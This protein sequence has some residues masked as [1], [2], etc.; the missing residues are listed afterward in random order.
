MNCVFV[1]RAARGLALAALTALIVMGGAGLS[2]AASS[3]GPTVDL[4]SAARLAPDGRTVFAD[5]IASCPERWTVVQAVVAVSQSQTSGRGS[6]PLTCIG[7]ARPFTVAVRTTGA[8][9][10]LGEAQATALVVIKRGRTERAQDSEVVDLNPDVFVNL[11]D[12]ALLKSGG[13]AVSMAVAAACAVGATGQASY[14][15]VSQGQAVGRGSYVPL[16]DGQR[17]TFTVRV[18]ASQ[19][20]FRAGS[21]RALTFA[22]VEAGGQSFSGVDDQPIQI[23]TG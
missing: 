10:H 15:N 22:F 11:A 1:P 23:V 6:F 12:S 5:V 2:Q 16:C 20:L 3:A 8:A 13:A 18:S 7:S 9:F 14:V 4:G 19:G 21:A 17:H